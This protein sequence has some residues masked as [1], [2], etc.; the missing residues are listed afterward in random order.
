MI[1]YLGKLNIQTNYYKRLWISIW[2][3]LTSVLKPTDNIYLSLIF[4]FQ[5]W[6][7]MRLFWMFPRIFCELL[8]L[9]IKFDD[10]FASSKT[11][12]QENSHWA[13]FEK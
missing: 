7:V 3:F 13:K 5:G 2:I 8:E 1:I 9:L 10:L 11:S 6:S 4:L 12:H